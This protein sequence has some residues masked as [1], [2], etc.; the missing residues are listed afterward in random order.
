M[1]ITRSKRASE[2]IGGDINGNE[3]G[4]KIEKFQKRG[5]SLE[6]RHQLKEITNKNKMYGSGKIEKTCAEDASTKDE[7]KNNRETT[8]MITESVVSFAD[9]RPPKI[10]KLAEEQNA[11]KEIIKRNTR[12]LIQTSVKKYSEESSLQIENKTKFPKTKSISLKSQNNV[13]NKTEEPNSITSVNN[14]PEQLLSVISNLYLNVGQR[15]HLD[16]TPRCLDDLAHCHR[17]HYRSD[18]PEMPPRNQAQGLRTAFE[19]LRYVTSINLTTDMCLR[20]EFPGAAIFKKLLELILSINYTAKQRPNITSQHCYNKCIELFLM[21]I[22]TFPPCWHKMRCYYI[23][24]LDRGLDT[25]KL[26]SNK[27][28]LP[29]KSSKV[30]DILLDLLE[31]LLKKC[32]QS[33]LSYPKSETIKIP[34]AFMDMNRA[35]SSFDVNF[36]SECWNQIQYEEHERE[37]Q[38]NVALTLVQR[39]ERIFVALRL[40]LHTLE[41]DLAMWVLHHNKNTKDWICSEN[42]PLIVMV[43]ELTQ[44]TR[45]TRMARR[46]F[47]VFSEAVAK[48]LCK[49]R[50]QVL[51]RYIS[52]LMVASNTMDMENTAIGVKYP[53][54]GEKTKDLI[55]DFFEIFKEHNREDITKYMENI[56]LLR[57]PFVRYEF[58]DSVLFANSEP[59]T[60]QKIAIDMAKKRWLK[61]KLF[62]ELEKPN[63]DISREQ[64]LNLLLNALRSYCDWHGLKTFWYSITKSLKITPLTT[65]G[66]SVH[67]WP[68]HGSGVLLLKKLAKD[69]KQL[70]AKLIMTVRMCKPKVDLPLADICIDE[71]IIRKYRQDLKFVVGLHN[72]L[73]KQK[74]EYPEVDFS[75]WMNFLNDFVLEKGAQETS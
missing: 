39:L 19:Q 63:E 20:G 61:Y 54:L 3:N 23:D 22:R 9:V 18:S 11:E 74:A 66:D 32:S 13:S 59:L 43:C 60:P 47:T 14:L 68:T 45:M 75:E 17:H 26:S 41:Y 50:L 42:R 51:E 16:F 25:S 36:S 56:E 28:T 5:D 8:T 30:C 67:R 58:I 37:L 71:T 48:G 53:V 12:T 52:L 70:E 1:P 62:A 49:S 33:D 2:L 73:L 69:V 6:L 24:F 64:Y 10:L 72:I 21:I 29:S 34:P 55:K 40:V 38:T 35:N 44:F 15:L 27:E 57:V 4:T 7:G 65:T 31:D 46:I